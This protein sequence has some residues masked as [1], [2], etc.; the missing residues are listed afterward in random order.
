MPTTVTTNI[1]SISNPEEVDGAYRSLFVDLGWGGSF[2]EAKSA[3]YN[4]R[5]GALAE[6][7][8]G[9]KLTDDV[10]VWLERKSTDFNPGTVTKS[11]ICTWVGKGISGN[12][13]GAWKRLRL[14]ALFDKARGLC[15]YTGK[16]LRFGAQDHSD[17]FAEL[18]HAIP[19]M[20][21]TK[22]GFYG[23]NLSPVVICRLDAN[24][25]RGHL[26]FSVWLDVLN[27]AKID[28]ERQQ[29]RKFIEEARQNHSLR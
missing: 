11:E 15:F 29:S 16:P 21:D 3:S 7:L 9:R 28:S 20:R 23:L 6:K 17:E 19:E 1:R 25:M 14:I 22:T 4:Y 2:E 8:L 24:R 27:D 13:W 18:D 10:H 12:D 26:P 5:A